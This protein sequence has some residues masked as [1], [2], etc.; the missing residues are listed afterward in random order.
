MLLEGAKATKIEYPPFELAH[1]LISPKLLLENP[2]LIRDVHLDYF[3]A[4]AQVAITASYQASPAGFAARGLDE[5]Q[6]R[7]L[8]GKSFELAR[9]AREAYLAENP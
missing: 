6:S 9:K 7:A 8:I 5:A 4:G 3:R 2:Q 1:S